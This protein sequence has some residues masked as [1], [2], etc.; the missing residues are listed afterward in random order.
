MSSLCVGIV[1]TALTVGV[2]FSSSRL[3]RAFPT[4]QTRTFFVTGVLLSL[5]FLLSAASEP[6]IA[7]VLA[8]VLGSSY[9]WHTAPNACWCRCCPGFEAGSGSGSP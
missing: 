1:L 2:W 5:G 4:S 8:G 3:P 7:W 9:Y 6:L